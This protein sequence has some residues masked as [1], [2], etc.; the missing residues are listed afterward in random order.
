M[1]S[2]K[3]E[4]SV[5]VYL[6][7]IFF[8]ANRTVLDDHTK[9]VHYEN[10]LLSIK[11]LKAGY[12]IFLSDIHVQISIV[13]ASSKTTRSHIQGLEDFI[14]GSNPMLEL[15]ESAKLPLY[16][17]PSVADGDQQKVNI[18]LYNWSPETRV[19]VL[20]SKFVPYGD[21]AFN[22]LNSLNAEEPWRMHKTLQTST[23]FKS[24]RV[25]GEEYQYVLN[26]KAHTTRWAGNLL[27]KPTTL[28]TPRVTCHICLELSYDFFHFLVTWVFNA[29]LLL[30]CRLLP[31]RPS[32]IKSCLET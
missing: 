19:C 10:G 28:L 11:G 5:L 7:D 17:S 8:F 31:R 3:H 14:V 15:L 23:A 27:T 6:T 29:L 9:N 2:E 32:Q 25:L 26:R 21:R 16:I 20:A 18:Q 22:N 24:G 4:L 12:Y 13:V 30:R 1:K